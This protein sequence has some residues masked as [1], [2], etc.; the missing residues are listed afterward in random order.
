M[1][2]RICIAIAIL[3]LCCCGTGSTLYAYNKED[4]FEQ[5]SLTAND[6]ME[7]ENQSRMFCLEIYSN[8]GAGN[9]GY[10]VVC[11]FGG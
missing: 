1:K 10:Y 7:T 8:C 3:L 6:V 2:K 11:P 9:N 5:E 4:C